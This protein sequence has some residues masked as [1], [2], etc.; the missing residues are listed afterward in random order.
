ME[1]LLNCYGRWVDYEEMEGVLCKNAA[2][3]SGL[4]WVKQIRTVGSRSIGAEDG[5]AA[6]LNGSAPGDSSGGRRLGLAAQL[7]NT[8]GSDGQADG[9]VAAQGTGGER[10][11]QRP[12]GTALWSSIRDGDRP[13]R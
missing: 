12:A 7:G 13:G 10:A 8:G 3:G 2:A 5:S 9:S 1:L 11:W 6:R 4:T